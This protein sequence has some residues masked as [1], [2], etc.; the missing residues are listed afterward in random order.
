MKKFAEQNLD[1]ALD[2]LNER[3]VFERS[4]VAFY[5]KIVEVMTASKD[6]GIQQMLPQMK[7]HRD[8]EKEH[9]EWLESQIRSLGGDAHA[10]TDHSKLVAIESEGIKEVIDGDFAL[11]HLFHALLQ[12][13]LSDNAGWQLLLELADEAGDDE[14][15]EAFRT[16]LHHEDEHLRMMREAVSTFARREVLGEQA[17]Q[18]PTG[19]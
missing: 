5:D 4:G 15:R 12:A 7:E 17:V 2:L 8:Q 6:A 10:E 16:R 3:L 11:P 19:P 14:A 13:E 9:E 1:Q 18:M